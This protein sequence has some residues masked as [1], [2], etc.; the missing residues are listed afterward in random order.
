VEPGPTEGFVRFN[1][2]KHEL[3]AVT[4]RAKVQVDRAQEVIAST[5]DE[6]K[7]I[8]LVLLGDSLV[9]G[10][11]DKTV[12]QDGPVLPRFLASILSTSLSVDVQWQACG[13]VGGTVE[14]IRTHLLPQVRKSL[15]QVRDGDSSSD[16]INVVLVICG[17]ND[18]K[19]VFTHFPLGSGPVQF[20]A[21]M[22]L[23]LKEV[24]EASGSEGLLFLP[25]CPVE[26]VSCRQRAPFRY[27]VDALA[28]VWDNKK[29]ELCEGQTHH[30]DE[31]TVSLSQRSEGEQGLSLVAS[32]GVHPSSFG[33]KMW[34]QHIGDRILHQSSSAI[35]RL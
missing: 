28:A 22:R 20:Q 34:A 14:E 25:A 3:E 21:D 12:S 10:V 35:M 26:Y 15:S 31:P 24:Q 23:L 7:K 27:F 6:R 11:G 30:I 17:M 16:V 18:F 8:N 29:L 5:P 13:K 19:T 2:V 33:Y 9:S 1:R 32:D 4:H